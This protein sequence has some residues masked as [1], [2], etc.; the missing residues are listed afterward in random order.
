M[1]KDIRFAKKHS[2]IK[3]NIMSHIR[4]YLLL[5]PTGQATATLELI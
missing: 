2:H 3:L 5:C 1:Q 4:H